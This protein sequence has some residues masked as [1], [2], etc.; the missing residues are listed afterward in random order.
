MANSTA[1]IK[2]N[3]KAEHKI[4]QFYAREREERD[5]EIKA[6]REQLKPI[7]IRVIRGDKTKETFH[8]HREIVHEMLVLEIEKLFLGYNGDDV[9]EEVA[10]QFGAE[11]VQEDKEEI[12]AEFKAAL[13]E[14]LN[15]S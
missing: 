1:E 6:L 5:E 15:T 11:N 7:N 9:I 13:E 3:L 2:K 4:D 8:E 10:R 14:G 12:L